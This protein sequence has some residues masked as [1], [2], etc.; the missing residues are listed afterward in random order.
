[1]DQPLMISLILQNEGRREGIDHP[2][3]DI[4]EGG[5]LPLMIFLILQKGRREG[6]KGWAN[7]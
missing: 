5:E 3:L 7:L 2:F 4:S 6:T 1:M